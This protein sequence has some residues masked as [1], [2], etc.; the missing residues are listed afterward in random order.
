[1][2]G[3]GAQA[4]RNNTI[5]LGSTTTPFLTASSGTSTGSYLVV[6]INGVDRKLLIFN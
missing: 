2:I 5:A 4:T 1:V 3:N 6:R